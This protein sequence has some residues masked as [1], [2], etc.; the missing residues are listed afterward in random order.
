MEFLKDQ[1]LSDL[2]SVLAIKYSGFLRVLKKS[3]IQYVDRLEQIG[4]RS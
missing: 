4:L 1:R 3:K 2:V